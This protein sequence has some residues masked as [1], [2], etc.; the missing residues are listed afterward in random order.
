MIAPL[1]TESGHQILSAGER[2]SDAI[3]AIE[4]GVEKYL[5]KAEEA[6]DENEQTSDFEKIVEDS[7]AALNLTPSLDVLR[8]IPEVLREEE[9]YGSFNKLS[10]CSVMG[11]A[12]H[13]SL[14]EME[15]I[16]G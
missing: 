10:P 7:L 5:I 8:R 9:T 15:F 12:S 1:R 3:S 6:K 16:L 11:F 14:S 4:S 2:S 13:A